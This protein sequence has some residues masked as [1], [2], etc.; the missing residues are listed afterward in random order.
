MKEKSRAQRRHH[1]QRMYNKA[2]KT[3]MVKSWFEGCTNKEIHI[4]TRKV[5]DTLKLC[6]CS[7]CC[8]PR[9]SGWSGNEKITMQER[10]Q[11]ESDRLQK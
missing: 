3:E 1:K 11:L 5:Q 7:M 9:N 10:K 6:S 4:K 8:N 2:K